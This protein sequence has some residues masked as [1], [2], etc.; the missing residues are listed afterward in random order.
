MFGKYP[1]LFVSDTVDV[2]ADL[3]K[4]D[5]AQVVDTKYPLPSCEIKSAP[6]IRTKSDRK[7]ISAGLQE[8]GL[9]RFIRSLTE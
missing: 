2:L 5:T 1:T 8:E 7:G 6:W 9:L 3:I 4:T